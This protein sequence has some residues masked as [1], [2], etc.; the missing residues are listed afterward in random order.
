MTNNKELPS[1]WSTG[2]IHK[3][4]LHNVI[5]LNCL[6]LTCYT[7]GKVYKRVLQ[8]NIYYMSVKFIF[9]FLYI[10]IYIYISLHM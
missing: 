3:A 10:C 4:K 6:C 5:M 9:I 1:M 7:F 2:L 8:L